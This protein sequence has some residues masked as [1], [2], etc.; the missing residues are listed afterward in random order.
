MIKMTNKRH[1]LGIGVCILFLGI[2]C[3][4]I[5]RTEKPGGEE[6]R[7]ENQFT[8]NEKENVHY[9]YLEK[10]LALML[11][12]TGSVS[13]CEVEINHSE[14]KVVGVDVGFAMSESNSGNEAMKADILEY[15]SKALDVSEDNIVISVH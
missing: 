9:H 5:L 4:V 11:E 6:I 14:G 3:F 15:F 1:V 2:A 8:D 13:D 10:Y 12:R 7:F